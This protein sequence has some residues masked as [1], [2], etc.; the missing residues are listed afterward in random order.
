MKAENT[1]DVM[2][3]PN[4]SW[5]IFLISAS[6]LFA[7]MLL[8]RWIGTEI[9]IFAYLQNT[10]LVACFIG[11]GL[12]LLTS[13]RK[14]KI[15]ESIMPLT[16]LTLLLAIPFTRGLLG[17]ISEMLS[18]MDDAIIWY[19]AEQTNVL[20]R[21]IMVILGLIIAYYVLILVVDTF[22]PLGRILG[23][24][25]NE[26]QNP[27]RAYSINILGS[28]VGNWCFVLLS[29]FNSK[30][31]VWF[32]A[33]VAMLF[34]FICK[35]R[36][37]RSRN[38]I[39]LVTTIVLSWFAGRVGDSIE[40]IWSPYQ[41]LVVRNT[42]V[43]E[44]GD[45]VVNVNN[46]GYQT[47]VDLSNRHVIGSPEVFDPTQRGLSQYDIPFLLNPEAK[48]VLIVGS[49][50]GNDVAGALRHNIEKI[51][52]VEIDPAIIKIGQRFHPEEPYAA[53]NVE[54][55][56]DDARSYFSVTK[57]K[58]DI[59]SFGLLDSHT[60]TAMTNTRLDH[61]VYT[62]ESI[63]QAKSLL[64]PGGII[65]LT[66]AVQRPFIADRMRNVIEEVFGEAPMMMSFPSSSY[67]W[68][69]LMFITGD[70]TVIRKQIDQNPYLS[71]FFDNLAKNTPLI[72]RYGTKIITDDWPYLYL[73]S[74]KIPTLYFFL[75]GVMALVFARS[76][77]KWQA[78]N[79]LQFYSS[80]FWHFFFLGA[81]FLFLEVQ[82][83]SKAS[84]VLGN[85]WQVN[86]I[87]VSG[88]LAMALAAN[89]LAFRYPKL[90]I[91]ISY[92]ALISI[93]IALYFFDLSF[94]CFLP[95]LFKAGAV[96]FLTSLPMLLSG[97][98]FVQSFSLVERR[99]LAL[100][101]NLV[102]ALVGALL[103]SMTFVV[104]V[105]ALLILVAM[106]YLFSMFVKPKKFNNG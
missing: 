31:Y 27:I 17:S 11:F 57:D 101:A 64:K 56:N 59:I 91:K 2:S 66:F 60:T 106:L 41:K 40:V 72:E 68:G 76:C 69:G 13:T 81:A 15:Q 21:I 82:N 26:D 65:T 89:W 96:A 48:K 43:G 50:A 36:E 92:I 46:V 35:D 9:R 54:I 105:K 94:L 33:L 90:P 24:L 93:C 67:G 14:I 55:I 39:L 1:N 5:G 19:S 38:I 79:C 3:I 47:I 61:Y 30:P 7:E 28:L 53:K 37:H 103:Q 45:F 99:D 20:S 18:T 88:V 85:T 70:S 74:P 52:A 4:L 32:I 95:L 34:V 78:V 58:Y 51:T 42:R 63:Q 8:I 62:R 80:N 25:I 22:V 87:I 100:G 10:I 86:S 75:I 102:G 104:G 12:G 77:K 49:G 84:V 73:Q 29:F 98:I 16:I 23:G 97:I 71:G 44:A 6:C 83:I